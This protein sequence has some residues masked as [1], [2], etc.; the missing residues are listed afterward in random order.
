MSK[1]Y[2]FPDRPW[3][4]WLIALWSLARAIAPI[5]ALI[6]AITLRRTFDP[7]FSNPFNYPSPAWL[8]DF[9]ALW[10]QAASPLMKVS[11]MVSLIAAA[12][13][14]Y[15]AI[16]ILLGHGWARSAFLIASCGLAAWNLRL[17]LQS[18]IGPSLYSLLAL[19]FASWYFRQPTIDAYFGGDGTSRNPLAKGIGRVPFDLGFAIL[20]AIILGA[21]ELVGV[22]VLLR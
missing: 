16:G 11:I 12:T 6:G 5:V 1:Q 10:S 19:F 3:S 20:L 18:R 13:F 4:I 17:V 2:E 8:S 9:L 14:L 15:A 21:T 7:Q 22:L